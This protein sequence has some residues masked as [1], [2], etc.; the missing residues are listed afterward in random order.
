MLSVKLSILLQYLHIFVPN[1]KANAIYWSCHALIWLNVLYYTITTFCEIFACSPIA[2]AWDPLITEGHCL[3][4][5]VFIN[6]SSAINSI[7]DIAILI[8]PQT[9]IW[10]LQLS[11][12]KKAQV[13]IIFLVGIL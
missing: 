6:A 10:K 1:K 13:S 12:K 4:T 8:L 3:P 7:S 5:L 9:V 2:K 11:T